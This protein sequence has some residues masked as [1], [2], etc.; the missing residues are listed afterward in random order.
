MP[1]LK[2]NYKK[3]YHLLSKFN[4]NYMGKEFCFARQPKYIL[5]KLSK[6]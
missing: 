5:R 4:S 3:G 2:A 6:T 1:N